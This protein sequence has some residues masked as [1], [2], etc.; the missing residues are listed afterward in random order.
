MVMKRQPVT[1]PVR[2]GYVLFAVLI[3]VVVLSLVAYRYAESMSTELQ[4][5]VRASE[6]GETKGF[7]S[8]A[9]T[10]PSACSPTRR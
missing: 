10:T 4:V 8:W 7:A 5:S 1:G 3:V 2:R 6:A 9:C